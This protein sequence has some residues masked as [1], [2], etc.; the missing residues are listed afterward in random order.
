MKLKD[1]I[2]SESEQWQTV[3]ELNEIPEGTFLV[4]CDSGYKGGAVGI[5]VI[6]KKTNHEYTP[7]SYQCRAKGPVHSESLAVYYAIKEIAKINVDIKT[8][9]ILTDSL[10]ACY[11]HTGYWRPSKKYIV[12][13]SEKI[14]EC[15]LLLPSVNYVKVS[16]KTN[17]RVDKIAKRNRHAA[18]EEINRNVENRVMEVEETIRKGESIKIEEI[19]GAY[20]A[21]S[22]KGDGKKYRVS[23]MPSSCECA[24]WNMRGDKVSE[25][26][27][28]TRRLPCKHICALASYLGKD[29]FTIFQIVIER[30]D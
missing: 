24:A 25:A 27:R 1:I 23:L 18:E 12:Y 17:K 7:K 6:I 10:Y 20:D 13:I 8:V 29:V 26:G 21:H 11:F 22:S 15:E 3:P 28:R 4:H 16:G 5:S 14:K 9:V 19:N 30:R 2:K